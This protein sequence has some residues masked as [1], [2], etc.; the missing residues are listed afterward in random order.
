VVVL[1]VVLVALAAGYLLGRHLR[2]RSDLQAA[3]EL[4]A[5]SNPDDARDRLAF[6]LGLWPEQGEV[7]FL[8]AR[9]ARRRDDLTAAREEL[10]ACRKRGYQSEELA[11]ERSLLAAQEGRLPEAE[12][13]VLHRLVLQEHPRAPLVLEALAKGYARTGQPGKALDCLDRLEQ[14]QPDNAR[15]LALRCRCATMLDR[16]EDALTS[17]RNAVKASPELA[18]V[19]LALADALYRFG[20]VRAAADQF[21]WLCA[22]HGDRPEP[23]VRLALCLEDLAEFGEAER[24]LDGL[25][26]G[27]PDFVPALVERG[28]VAFRLGQAETGE[29]FA[30]QAL[31]LSPHDADAPLVLSQC[32]AASGRTEEAGRWLREWRQ[33]D[34]D[35][36]VLPWLASRLARSPLDPDLLA[37][38]GVVLLRLGRD[39]EG[40]RCLRKVLEMDPGNQRAQAALADHSGKQ[41]GP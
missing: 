31:K 38:Q 41:G 15:A 13:G 12:E 34:A 19:R 23:V 7:R 6:C 5:G 40:V 20:H 3:R 18:E 29:R 17:G 33:R 14:T 9:A 36:A 37:Q 25:L 30:R 4:L 10:D 32:L 21:E 35:A 2:G 22:R 11:L 1:G 27:H 28:R 8:A 24:L 39:E 26:V 16:E